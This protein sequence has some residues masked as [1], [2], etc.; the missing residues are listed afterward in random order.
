[1]V[2]LLNFV[3]SRRSTLFPR[4][5][6]S[7]NS[8]ARGA[9]PLLSSQSRSASLRSAAHCHRDRSMHTAAACTSEKQPLLCAFVYIHAFFVRKLM[10]LRRA[11]KEICSYMRNC[12]RKSD[13]RALA[14][15]DSWFGD[16]D[17]FRGLETKKRARDHVSLLFS[18][19]VSL[20][21]SLSLPFASL[22]FP[23]SSA[24]RS[25]GRQKTARRRHVTTTRI[26]KLLVAKGRVWSL[27]QR[28][29]CWNGSWSA[30]SGKLE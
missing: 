8:K 10:M 24:F 6:T 1:M 12:R 9:G 17:S 30:L 2:F 18:F 25:R 27:N 26:Q 23:Q 16:F 3:R 14:T 13:L 15:L 28:N 11:H 20:S 4:F 5:L 19:S 22:V 21:L 29:E 7:I